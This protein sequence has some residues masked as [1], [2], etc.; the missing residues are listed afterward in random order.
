MNQWGRDTCLVGALSE[1]PLIMRKGHLSL[2]ECPLIMRKGH[3]SLSECPLITGCTV[4][5]CCYAY[6][7]M[8]YCNQFLSWILMCLSF[9]Q[10]LGE[11]L[12]E[13]CQILIVGNVWNWRCIASPTYSSCNNGNWLIC[14]M[15]KSSCHDV[16]FFLS[17]H[18]MCRNDC[19]NPVKDWIILGFN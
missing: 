14:V 10:I 15:N 17:S 5:M 16:F 19:Q 2:S 4:Y 1:C 7:I 6:T 12:K 9:G 11:R 3:L 8:R 18:T 13:I